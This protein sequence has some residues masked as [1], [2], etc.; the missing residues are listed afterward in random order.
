MPSVY[1]ARVVRHLRSVRPKIAGFRNGKAAEITVAVAVVAL[2]L[3][4][5]GGDLIRTWAFGFLIFA[6]IP[7][8]TVL[9][10]GGSEGHFPQIIS[11]KIFVGSLPFAI[12]P[13]GA[14]VAV[15]RALNRRAA[16]VRPIILGA[17][18]VAFISTFDDGLP[19]C[20]THLAAA[21]LISWLLYGTRL[22]LHS[23]APPVTT[24]TRRWTGALG[25]IAVTREAGGPW[26]ERAV[27]DWL[28]RPDDASGDTVR[29]IVQSTLADSTATDSLIGAMVDALK[30][31]G[32]PDSVVENL[33]P[34]VRRAVVQMLPRLLTEHSLGVMARLS[35]FVALGVAVLALVPVVVEILRGITTRVAVTLQDAPSA[36]METR[37]WEL[38]DKGWLA[39]VGYRWTDN[40]W[41]ERQKSPRWVDAAALTPVHRRFVPVS[42]LEMAAAF[43]RGLAIGIVT[44]CVGYAAGAAAAFVFLYGAMRHPSTYLQTLDPGSSL[45]LGDRLRFQADFL[46][47]A[48]QVQRTGLAFLLAVLGFGVAALAGLAAARNRREL[49]ASEVVVSWPHAR[50]AT[51]HYG[52]LCS[53]DMIRYTSR[54]WQARVLRG[55]RGAVVGWFDLDDISRPGRQIAGASVTT[56]NGWRRWR[57]VHL[58]RR[59]RISALVVAALSSPVIMRDAHSI[60]WVVYALHLVCF[61]AVAWPR[62]VII[63]VDQTRGMQMRLWRLLTGRTH[64][65][66]VGRIFHRARTRLGRR[67]G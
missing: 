67:T 19:V 9:G 26:A 39:L 33:E 61:A 6:D 14:A 36:P 59:I 23:G 38:G 53:V 42:A 10:V 16:E 52:T 28:I 45:P 49:I 15:L 29:A 31:G 11:F 40:D 5:A 2:S 17:F 48:A 22:S 50:S 47:G 55:R 41:V 64:A 62:E 30:E 3:Y 18:V 63:L 43:W 34:T 4:H 21:A 46:S 56:E 12:V 60:R 1:L 32:M 51:E 8:G 65:S 57:E 44:A 7:W 58:A 25:G 20:L 24:A 54:G 66:F 37:G 27:T 13:F 35:G